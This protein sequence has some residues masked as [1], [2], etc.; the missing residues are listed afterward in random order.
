MHRSPGFAAKDY[1]RTR[2]DATTP[3]PGD[4]WPP[5]PLAQWQDTY[6]TLHMWTQIVGKTR[7]ALAPMENHWWN[8]ALYVTPRGLTT[9]AMPLG[10][11][12]FAA[13]FDFID[14]QLYVRDSRG[15]SAA[16]P[17]VPQ[18]VAD[19][20]AAWQ[21][22][23]RSLAIDVRIM[24]V[25][26]EVQTAIPFAEDREHAAYDADA[27]HR[28]WRILPR[29]VPRQ[30]ESRPLLLGELRSGRDAILRPT[31][32]ASFGRRAALSR[33]RDGR[34]LFPRVRE[35]RVLAGW[36]RARRTGVLRVCIPGAGR[37]CGSSRPPT[38]SALPSGH[39]RVHPAVR[40]GPSRL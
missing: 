1:K 29:P 27:A 19:F 37:V 34:G 16:I 22:T 31:G 14:H 18:S 2:P 8:V 23:L 5:L 12:T 20:Y 33:L 11:R 3:P 32:A 24:P 9:S 15:A 21:E 26:V 17:L 36:G 28:C 38:G 6:A 40:G 7:L 39:A 30:G 10:N 25:P 35:L 13:D 4:A